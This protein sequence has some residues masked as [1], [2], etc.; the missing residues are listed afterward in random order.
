MFTINS[1][2][3]GFRPL[4]RGSPESPSRR[5]RIQLHIHGDAEYIESRSPLSNKQ[6]DALSSK[7]SIP[8]VTVE[9]SRACSVKHSSCTAST[10]ELQDPGT[11]LF[12]TPIQTLCLLRSH[13]LHRVGY[14]PHIS[15]SQATT[16][17]HF[18]SATSTRD[19]NV[20]ML[21]VRFLISC[22]LVNIQFHVRLGLNDATA[23][24]HPPLDAAP[25]KRST[26]F[27][28]V[29]THGFQ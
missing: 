21:N 24:V 28:E 29:S 13:H 4:P 2:L 9:N 3:P 1:H 7:E 6:R 8:R 14:I 22:F 23:S 26:F 15:A 16:I 27:K 5:H 10:F 12:Y 20:L 11:Y 18:K 17:D 19:T 25:K